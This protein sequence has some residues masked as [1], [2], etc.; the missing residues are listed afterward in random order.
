M[1]A[2]CI[3]RC[4]AGSLASHPPDA[5]STTKTPVVT[6]K[7]S[8]ALPNVLWCVCVCVGKLPLDQNHGASLSL[9]TVGPQLRWSCE[10]CV[11]VYASL[12]KTTL[13]T[14]SLILICIS[15]NTFHEVGCN[16]L[17]R[18]AISWDFKGILF[19]VTV[20]S[21]SDI[22]PDPE[23]F[24]PRSKHLQTY[25]GMLGLSN[26]SVRELIPVHLM[27]SNSLT[28]AIT[29]TKDNLFTTR[30]EKAHVFM[31]ENRLMNDNTTKPITFV[32]LLSVCQ[33]MS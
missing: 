22:K 21:C 6:T 28:C 27:V 7:T 15:H 11:H 26:C 30:T 29:N 5:S 9:N 19:W 12:F 2:P 14:L 4:L 8:R 25:A 33:P 31:D 1:A 23:S 32:C 13:Y 16:W 24:K 18:R 3:V 17:K 20:A 10:P